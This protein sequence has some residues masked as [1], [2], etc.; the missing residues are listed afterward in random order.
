M[1]EWG[2]EST[3]RRW[4]RTHVNH[5]GDVVDIIFGHDRVCRRQVQQIVVPGFGAFQLVLGVLGLPLGR[6]EDTGRV[7]WG[8][9]G[10]E[11]TGG[12]RDTLM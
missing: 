5:I 3:Q 11:G 6:R 7:R 2:G 12:G 10:G 8:G 4:A 1:T 9:G